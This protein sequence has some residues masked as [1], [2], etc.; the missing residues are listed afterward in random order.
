MKIFVQTFTILQVTIE[1]NYGTYARDQRKGETSMKTY[2]NYQQT[3]VGV[4]AY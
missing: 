3:R 1:N 4:S 2:K